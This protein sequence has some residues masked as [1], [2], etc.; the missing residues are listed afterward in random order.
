MRFDF[1]YNVCLK[2]FSSLEELSEIWSEMYIGLHVKYPLFLSDFNETGQIFEK[3]VGAELFHA[4][5]QTDRQTWRSPVVALRNFANTP[6]NAKNIVANETN[7]LLHAKDVCYM[8]RV[9]VT[10]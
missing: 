8:L 9:S 3:Y 6:K 2:P 7:P 4:D 10:C 5:G 1:L